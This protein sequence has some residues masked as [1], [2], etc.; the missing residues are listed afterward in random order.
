[1]IQEILQTCKANNVPTTGELFFGLAFRTE[2][3]LKSICSQLHINTQELKTC[4]Q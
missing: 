1:M 3:E 4:N 2:N